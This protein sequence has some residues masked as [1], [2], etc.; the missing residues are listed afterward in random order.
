MGCDMVVGVTVPSDFLL[1]LGLF[2]AMC[3]ASVTCLSVVSILCVD[4]TLTSMLLIEAAC[5]F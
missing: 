4:N 1:R 2:T 3:V 5:L